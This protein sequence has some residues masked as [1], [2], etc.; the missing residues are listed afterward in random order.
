MG[1][2]GDDDKP[3]HVTVPYDQGTIGMIGTGHDIAKNA[4]PGSEAAGL[5][6][7]TRGYLSSNEDTNR[8]LRSQGYLDT[9][10]M[11]RALQSTQNRIA[12][13]NQNAQNVSNAVSG[14]RRSISKQAVDNNN[15]MILQ[16]HVVGSAMRQIKQTADELQ[17]RYAVIGAGFR[18]VG[19]WLAYTQRQQANKGFDPTFDP[20]RMN[21]PD[22]D[23][24]GNVVPV[25][26]EMNSRPFDSYKEGSA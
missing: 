1:F 11:A 3:Q 9:E 7:S 2:F 26:D 8:A 12:G 13:I 21:L 5:Q 17:T 18:G 24:D 10:P 15:Q 4:T 14:A 22:F 23:K 25:K 19:S 6:Q 16:S 20:S